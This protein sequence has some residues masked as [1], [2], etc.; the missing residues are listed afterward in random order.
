[1]RPAG[2]EGQGE[3]DDKG[4]RTFAVSLSV[5]CNNGGMVPLGS[6]DVP[7]D[8]D[9]GGRGTDQSI[10]I[11]PLAW[12]GKEKVGNKREGLVLK[13]RISSDYID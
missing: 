1:M 11:A 13:S 9:E 2:V 3:E 7:M 12:V 6:I 8:S 10:P 4:S 5:M